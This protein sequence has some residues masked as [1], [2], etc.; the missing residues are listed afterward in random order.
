MTDDDP[1][2]GLD[3]LPWA[4]LQH[5][6][7]MADALAFLA[8]TPARP[9]DATRAALNR[10]DHLTRPRDPL[11][12]RHAVRAAYSDPTTPLRWSTS[13]RHQ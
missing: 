6:Y 3:D 10:P 9:A 8:A 11:T 12:H 4:Q 7:G 1:L 5:S 13:R 2:T